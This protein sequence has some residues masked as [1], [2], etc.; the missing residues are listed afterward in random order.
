MSTTDSAP[1][2]IVNNRSSLSSRM[3]I[4]LVGGSLIATMAFCTTYVS[5]RVSDGLGQKNEQIDYLRTK[6]RDMHDNY[7]DVVDRADGLADANVDLTTKNTTLT[8]EKA[9]ALQRASRAEGRVVVLT[10]QVSGLEVANANLTTQNTG[11]IK[12]NKV[13]RADVARGNAKNA[14]QASLIDELKTS[15]SEAWDTIMSLKGTVAARSYDQFESD[16]E[17]RICDH[18]TRNKVADCRAMVRQAMKDADIETQYTFC[19]S[20]GQA[21]ATLGKGRHAHDVELGDTGEF[22]HL[23]DAT[24][25]EAP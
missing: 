1:T 15:L 8:A 17:L 5:D 6:W 18:G 22:V 10:T 9:A 7:T 13:L 2:V 4:A 11:L 19:V 20:S 24:L 16:S 25:P 14:A 3:F 12:E 21:E 23:C